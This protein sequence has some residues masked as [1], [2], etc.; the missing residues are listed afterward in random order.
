MTTQAEKVRYKYRTGS[1]SG[2]I[3]DAIRAKSAQGKGTTAIRRELRAEGFKVRNQVVTDVLS[4]YKEPKAKAGGLGRVTRGSPARYVSQGDREMSTE[5]IIYAEGRLRRV[6][7]GV[8]G[9]PFTQQKFY[10]SDTI[11]TVPA[12]RERI[13]KIIDSG[14]P[15][16]VWYGPISEASLLEM[17]DFY[18]YFFILESIVITSI[19]RRGLYLD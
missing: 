12:I 7:S 17:Y 10:G 18:D 1:T 19:E 6:A 4:T 16:P 9:E 13:Y 14:L 3:R 11:P 5:Y 8:V 2:D 15:A